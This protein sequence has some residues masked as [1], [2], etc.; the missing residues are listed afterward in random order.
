MRVDNA[1]GPAWPWE[2]M[3][4]TGNPGDAPG[5]SHGIRAW[6]EVLEVGE[7]SLPFGKMGLTVLFLSRGAG[8]GKGRWWVP[9]GDRD[10]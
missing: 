1:H 9:A 7:E 8:A 6:Q 10:E 5:Q 3:C 4:E 2:G